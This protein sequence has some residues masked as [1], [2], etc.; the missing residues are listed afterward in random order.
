MVAWDLP[1]GK[2]QTG[3]RKLGGRAVCGWLDH[4]SCRHN[5]KRGIWFGSTLLILILREQAFLSGRKMVNLTGQ[6]IRTS[7]KR[8]DLDHATTPSRWLNRAVCIPGHYDSGPR[9]VYVNDARSEG[10]ATNMGFIKRT[11]ITETVNFE[12]RGEFINIFNRT[13]FGITGLRRDRTL[14][15]SPDSELPAVLAPEHVA[16]PDRGKNQF[17]IQRVDFKFWFIQKA[18]VRASLFC[19]DFLIRQRQNSLNF[20]LL[21]LQP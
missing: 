7:V 6:P 13:N 8:G 16:R 11:R 12:I 14:P 5:I 20:S 21:P 2:G 4:L 15:I 18:G 3:G 17:L 19:L 1:F 9:Q 10:F